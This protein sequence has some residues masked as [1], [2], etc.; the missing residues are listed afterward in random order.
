MILVVGFLR[1]LAQK[2]GF[3]GH[4]LEEGL[5]ISPLRTSNF[6]QDLDDGKKSFFFSIIFR[7]CPFWEKY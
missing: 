5:A 2:L 7:V 1:N 6:S 4:D 3:L